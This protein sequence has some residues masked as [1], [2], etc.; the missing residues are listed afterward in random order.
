MLKLL[1]QSRKVEA[2]GIG[3]ESTPE[4]TVE[5]SADASDDNDSTKIET[6]VLAT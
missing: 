3:R 4:A 1:K 5:G 6:Q 2:E